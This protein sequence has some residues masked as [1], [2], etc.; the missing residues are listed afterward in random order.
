MF[1]GLKKQTVPTTTVGAVADQVKHRD[2]VRYF[3]GGDEAD[4]NREFSQRYDTTYE[5]R[6]AVRLAKVFEGGA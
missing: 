1:G 4:F 3:F 5:L 6:R 2:N